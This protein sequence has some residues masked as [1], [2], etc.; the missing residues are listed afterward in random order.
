MAASAHFNPNISSERLCFNPEKRDPDKARLTVLCQRSIEIAK[1]SGSTIQPEDTASLLECKNVREEVI[2]EMGVQPDVENIRKMELALRF[3][4]VPV[5]PYKDD[6]TASL[7]S[8]SVL[9]GGTLTI[10]NHDGSKETYEL[11]VRDALEISAIMAIHMSRLVDGNRYQ[12]TDLQQNVKALKDSYW[13]DWKERGA[14]RDFYHR[15]LYPLMNM[16]ACELSTKRLKN[17]RVLEVCAGDGVLAGY[18]L[19]RNPEEITEY[20][21]IELNER[22][23]NKAKE[24][25]AV[26]PRAHV[27]RGDVTTPEAY[28]RATGGKKVGLVIGS[29]ALTHQVL[30]DRNIALAALDQIADTLEDGGFLLLSGV[31]GHWVH[32]K[33]LTERNFVVLNQSIPYSNFSEYPYLQFFVA[34]KFVV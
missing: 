17:R 25:L 31:S 34:Q 27:H 33:D 23:C 7:L 6:G 5:D 11:T 30:P 20:S 15:H 12:L 29:G 13:D 32:A 22:S 1:K 26:E 2:F 4:P 3:S 18:I 9:P 28:A 10:Y 16:F 19:Q 21:L 8:A 24:N 14:D